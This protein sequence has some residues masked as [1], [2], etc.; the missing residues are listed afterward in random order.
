MPAATTPTTLATPAKSP[1]AAKLSAIIKCDEKKDLE[2]YVI[3]IELALN[4]T[5]VQDWLPDHITVDLKSVVSN[6]PVALQ[7][8][9][10]DVANITAQYDNELDLAAKLAVKTI[11]TQIESIGSYKTIQ[12]I[13]ENAKINDL[14]TLATACYIVDKSLAEA[15]QGRDVII[16]CAEKLKHDVTPDHEMILKSVQR[17][18]EVIKSKETATFTD[19]QIKS[20][21]TEL[22]ALL[23]TIR[24][25]IHADEERVEA[26]G[27]EFRRCI[28]RHAYGIDL[29]LARTAG[30][31]DV[32]LA[33]ETV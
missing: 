10:Q 4:Q 23:T 17:V 5:E 7:K 30:R 15:T 25:A 19:E 26:A 11:K 31:L 9:L 6:A 3:Q 27:E 33:A 29:D 12:K 32:V 16:G 8:D 2:Y 1:D 28:F 22:Q 20:A 24:N 21:S 13:V 18:T 14:H